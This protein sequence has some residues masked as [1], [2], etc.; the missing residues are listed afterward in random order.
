MTG[1]VL[2]N[3]STSLTWFW[4]FQSEESFSL[5]LVVKKSDYTR[6]IVSGPVPES[7]CGKFSKGIPLIVSARVSTHTKK[8]F[9]MNI[10]LFTYNIYR[11]LSFYYYI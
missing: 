7:F 2:P 5:D 4:Y 8:K 6:D 11:L 9:R 3:L 1:F 10:T